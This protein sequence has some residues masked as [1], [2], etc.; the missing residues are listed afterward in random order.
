MADARSLYGR[1]SFFVATDGRG[2]VL[3][4]YI[5]SQILY[6]YCRS[7]DNLEISAG[8]A[9]EIREVAAGPVVIEIVWSLPSSPEFSLDCD[10]FHFGHK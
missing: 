8:P 1:D 5:N 6:F 2:V 9:R 3:A 10:F 4:C 7:G